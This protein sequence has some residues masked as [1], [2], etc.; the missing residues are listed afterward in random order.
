MS[1]YWTKNKEWGEG[2][3]RHPGIL[4]TEAE[5]MTVDEKAERFDAL[6]KMC[7]ELMIEKTNGKWDDDYT[8]YIFE[9]AL[10]C[11]LAPHHIET[12]LFWKEWSE[13]GD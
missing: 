5:D 10:E 6:Q 1:W 13:I 4:I 7:K 12:K 11:T 2:A 3:R 8:H 9:K